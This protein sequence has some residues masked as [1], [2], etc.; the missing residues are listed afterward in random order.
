MNECNEHVPVRVVIV[1]DHA[2]VRNALRLA[3]E[4][5]ERI[6]VVGEAR[7]GAEAVSTVRATAPDVV[8]L[9][10]RLGDLDAP[11]VIECIRELGCSAEFVVLTSYGNRRTVRAAVDQGARA[12]LTKRA[13]DI[14]CLAKAVLD[15]HAG[16][17]TLSEDALAE[18]LNS[19]RDQRARHEVAVS[20]RAREV[21]QLVAD[22]KS[23]ADIAAALF[24]SER[25]VK[26]HV[27]NLLEA[28]GARS[29][30]ELVAFA[31]R[32]GV[33]DIQE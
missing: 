14:D 31:Y 24:L 5:E 7:S 21:W 12:F 33:M 2:L 27:G 6:Q 4:P 19:V 18:L 28:T 11:E 25:T 30:A 10:Y 23:N 20:P 9:D 32:S 8:V 22:G 13:T 17:D 16:K 15:A 29:R 1:D 3:L 26:Y